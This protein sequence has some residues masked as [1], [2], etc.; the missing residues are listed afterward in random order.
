MAN[1]TAFDKYPEAYDLWFAENSDLYKAE[2][3]AVRYFLPSA[4]KGVEIGVGTG[5]FA[6]PLGIPLGV[7]PSSGMA[8]IA[9]Q[10]GLE[11]VKGIAEALPFAERA[12]D[13]VLMVTIEGFLDDLSQAMS[14]AARILKPQGILIVGMI[15]RASGPGRACSRRKEQGRFC[16]GASFYSVAEME[17]CL[18]KAGFGNFAHRQTLFSG[19]TGPRQVKEGHGRGGFAVIRAIKAGEVK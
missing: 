5:R 10:R 8:L 19:R 16:R 1:T 15:D 17:G 18:T 3:E 14:E 6:A 7:E 13:F 12:F 9:R 4:G 2:L 11:V